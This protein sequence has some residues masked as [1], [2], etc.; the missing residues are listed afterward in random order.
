MERIRAKL[1]SETGAS[2][3]Y[4][5][6]LFL[7]CAVLSSVILVAATAAAGRIS[8]LAETDQ[9]YY[10]VTSAAELVKKAIDGKE[11]KVIT[12]KDGELQITIYKNG[13]VNSDK[14]NA[15]LEDLVK[16]NLQNS[17]TGSLSL[18]VTPQNSATI[19]ITIDEAWDANGM[20]NISVYNDSGKEKEGKF[21]LFLSFAADIKDGDNNPY[22]DE[23]MMTED[24][25]TTDE[26]NIKS[27]KYY[28]WTLTGMATAG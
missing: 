26:D 24:E 20:L 18:K 6:L 11:A 4:G 12:Y 7:V 14:C 13:E 17:G 3:T 21:R 27:I 23:S 22:P 9:R 10:S 19:D 8:N 15:I 5:L 1:K 16:Q 28:S 25:Q 2:I